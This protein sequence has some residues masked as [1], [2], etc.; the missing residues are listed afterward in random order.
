MWNAIA[1]SV[2]YKLILVVLATNFA[3][4]LVAGAALSI[5]ELRNYRETLV[6]DLDTQGEILGRA[7]APALAFD[8]PDSANAYLTLLEA[9]PRITAAAI[10]NAK[11]RLFAGYQRSDASA[12][13]LPALPDADGY[14]VDGETM[15]LFTRIVED[16]EILGTVYLRAEYGIYGRLAHYLGILAAV[17][18]SSMLVA[19]LVVSWLQARLTKPILAVTDIARQV[20]TRRDYSLRAHKTTDDEIGYLVDTF[21]GMLAEIGVRSEANEA[22]NRRLEQEVAERQR[23]EEDL[24]KLNLELEQRVSER[25]AQLENVNKELEAFSYS[26]SHDLRAPLRAITGFANLLIEDHADTLDGEAHRKLGVILGEAHRMGTLIDDLLAFSRLGRK[27]MQIVELDMAAMARH[28]Y[29]SLLQQHEGTPAEL[30]I[31]A[32][33]HCQGDRTLIGQVWANL[34]ANALK[35][36]AHRAKPVIE[37]NAISD[38]HE[39]VYFVRDNGAGFD[40]RYHS[41]LFEVFQRLHDASEFPG[42]GVGLALVRRIVSRHGGRVWAEGKPDAGATFYF[43]LPRE[44]SDGRI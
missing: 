15:E 7:S 38:D 26:V 19:L 23:A 33:P 13:A 27:D 35:F 39:H 18:L 2:R 29:D 21:N 22:A 16:D 37:V 5:Y 30:R 34:L 17:M 24:R 1:Q 8:D 42:T 28:T 41:K 3:A 11:G 25:T 10:Y 44:S 6:N 40:N 14:R 31:A 9:R 43:T 20:M 4:L 36:S 12:T 32:L